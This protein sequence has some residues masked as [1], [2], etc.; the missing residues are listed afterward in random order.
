MLFVTECSDIPP[1]ENATPTVNGSTAYQP[2]EHGTE[3]DYECNSGYSSK[4]NLVA[5]CTSG[6]LDVSS[7][8]CYRGN[9]FCE[10]KSF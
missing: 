3:V 8:K 4:G 10:K 2:I 5:V 1:V 7:F 9:V 6:V